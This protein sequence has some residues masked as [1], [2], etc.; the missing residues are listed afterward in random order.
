MPARVKK[1]T[2]EHLILTKVFPLPA[3]WYRDVFT[4]KM[5]AATRIWNAC[6]WES[7]ETHKREGRW[8]TEAQIK[9]RLKEF[10]TWRELAAQSARAVVEE[11]F[12]AVRAY[13]T[14]RLMVIGSNALRASSPRRLCAPSFGRK[15]RPASKTA[16]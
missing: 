7:D 15:K 2:A 5:R 10:A 12:Q 16:C 1:N 13:N 11:Y 14:H 4:P 6:K 3:E 9:A 8:P